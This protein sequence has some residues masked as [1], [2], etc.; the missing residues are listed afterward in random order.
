MRKKKM[1]NGLEEGK[2]KRSLK[3][4]KIDVIKTKEEEN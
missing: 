1:Q 3:R 2:A 4:N